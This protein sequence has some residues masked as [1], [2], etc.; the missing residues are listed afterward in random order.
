MNK[1]VIKNLTDITLY[2]GRHNLP[3]RGHRKGW[4]DKIHGNVK[5]LTIL[6]AKYSSPL[7]LHLIEVQLKGK[8]TYNFISWQRQSQLI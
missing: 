4:K 5:D 3:Y 7:A 8:H 1:E 6:L 2:L